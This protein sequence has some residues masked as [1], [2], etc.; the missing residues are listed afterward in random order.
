MPW[1][2]KY[3]IASEV[4]LPEELVLQEIGTKPDHQYKKKIEQ[5]EK[6]VRALQRMSEVRSNLG[7]IDDESTVDSK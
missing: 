2:R 7:E 5:L 3:R 1:L 6:K 4:D